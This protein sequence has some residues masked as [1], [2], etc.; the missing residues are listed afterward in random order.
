MKRQ[1]AVFQILVAVGVF[2]AFLQARS[3]L[4]TLS[5]VLGKYS[6]GGKSQVEVYANTKGEL[7]Y[8]FLLNGSPQGGA[9]LAKK[10]GENTV[11]Y[12]DEGA[13][14]LWVVTPESIGSIDYSVP[15]Y[16]KDES[17]IG[18]DIESERIPKPVRDAVVLSKAGLSAEGALVIEQILGKHPLTERVQIEIYADTR[19]GIW[20]SPIIDGKPSGGSTLAKNTGEDTVFY[21]DEGTSILWVITPERVGRSDF[22]KPEHFST[23]SHDINDAA[24]LTPPKPVLEAVEKMKPK[25]E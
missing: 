3:E 12:W 8:S 5:H 22:S 18:G 15:K 21:W 23:E 16:I 11:L 7:W 1:S 24:S 10:T 13:S 2:F 14:K 4:L 19:N 6:L 9:A 25:S 17:V 20:Y